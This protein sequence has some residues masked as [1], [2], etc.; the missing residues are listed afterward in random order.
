MRFEPVHDVESLRESLDESDFDLYLYA[1]G[2]PN[3]VVVSSVMDGSA[4][5]TNGL[6]PDDVI[7]RYA[8]ER[9]FNTRELR[10]KTAAGLA[11]ETV[12]VEVLRGGELL[13]YYLPRG[14]I[15]V[16]LNLDRAMPN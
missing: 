8:G 4:A 10:D 12:P 3:R 15:G 11:G 1:T 5:A 14:P 6:E 7:F 2:Q 16:R 9:V 13:L